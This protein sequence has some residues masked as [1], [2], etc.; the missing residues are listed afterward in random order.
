MFTGPKVVPLETA[1]FVRRMQG[2]RYCAWRALVEGLK[3]GVGVRAALVHLP[4]DVWLRH[5]AANEDAF[6]ALVAELQGV[7]G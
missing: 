7:D 1:L 3:T 5:F 4:E 6:N 2:E